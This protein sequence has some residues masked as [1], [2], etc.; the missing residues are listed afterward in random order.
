MYDFDNDG[1]ITSEDVRIMMSY[2]PIH[3]NI[4]VNHVQEMIDKRGIEAAMSPSIQ[5]E[6]LY[7]EEEGKNMDY[8]DRIS[9]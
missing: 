9:D 4:K 8:S 1:Y 6:G 3:K 5:K 7:Q 2:M